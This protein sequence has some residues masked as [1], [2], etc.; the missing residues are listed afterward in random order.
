MKSAI[1][2][3]ILSKRSSFIVHMLVMAT[4]E[5]NSLFLLQVEL[6]SKSICFESVRLQEYVY[7]SGAESDQFD[8]WNRVYTRSAHY[9]TTNS[10]QLYLIRFEY[11]S[12]RWYHR[13][14]IGSIPLAFTL[15]AK[16]DQFELIGICVLV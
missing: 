13:K 5:S 12:P 16:S 14:R 1:Y 15:R 2:S 11:H 8:P 10:I 7:T 3:L 6:C 4:K 9:T